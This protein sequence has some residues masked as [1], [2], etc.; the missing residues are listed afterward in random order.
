[1]LSV[2]HSLSILCVLFCLIL[3]MCKRQ[4]LILFSLKIRE[5]KL[6]EVRVIP[7]VMQPQSV[8]KPGVEISLILGCA[9]CHAELPS[10][11]LTLI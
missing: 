11:I 9:Y 1:M 3:K 7:K 4:V 2:R 10:S 8:E 6:K 5:P